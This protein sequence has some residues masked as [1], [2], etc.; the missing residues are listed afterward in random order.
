[1]RRRVGLLALALALWPLVAGAAPTQS[2]ARARAEFERGEYKQVLKTLTTEV[3]M[4]HEEGDLKEAHYLLGVAYFYTRN[5]EMARQEFTA[6]LYLDPAH[7]LDKLTESPEVY[8]FYDGLKRELEDKLEAIQK[9]REKEAEARRLPQR[10]I[11]V[12]RTIREPAPWANF[13]PFGYGQFR[14]GQ[15]A[16]GVFFLVSES[17]LGGTSL[18]MFTYQAVSYGIPSRYPLDADRD[19]IRTRQYIQVG[20]GALFLVTY[21]WGTIDAFSNQKP[22][23]SEKTTERPITA[24]AKSPTSLLINPVI[25]PVVAPELV[26]VGVTWRF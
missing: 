22:L 13:L 16:K 20:T 25:S 11:L 9:Q 17:L 26:G 15:A 10:E 7:E 2:L 8:A 3:A 5:R 21:I 12:E 4:L 23:V 19:A 24:P 18:A 1:M 14:N 6:L